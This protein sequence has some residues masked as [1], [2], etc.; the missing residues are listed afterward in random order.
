M[1]KVQARR[2]ARQLVLSFA[3]SAAG[4]PQIPASEA[5]PTAS[6]AP[7]DAGIQL[8][9]S[10][11]FTDAKAYFAEAVAKNPSDA[12][13]TY[14]LGRCGVAMNDVDAAIE[15]FE[16]AVAL[17]DASAVYHHWLGRA[18]GEKALNSGMFKKL[19]LAPKVRKEME[20]AVALDPNDLGARAD[21]L[22]YYMEAP[23]IVGGSA[24]KALEQAAEIRK[25]DALAGHYAYV[26]VYRRQK[27]N[28]LVEQEY[29]AATRENPA[30]TEP[31]IQLGFFYQGAERYDDALRV[32]E[33]IVKGDPNQTMALY[34]VGKTGA[35]SGRNLDR[36]AEC[37]LAYIQ[38]TPT[39]DEPPLTF[40]HY[41]LGQ[42][43]EKKGDVAA[44]KTEYAAALA[45]DPNNKDAKTALKKIS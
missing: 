12:E 45:L 8:F 33:G 10:K 21:L 13:S 27:K 38:H 22:D 41:R 30:K 43:Y 4:A 42:V 3:L 11:K 14:Y 1:T 17:Q 15:S 44:A 20:R 32:F 34:Q 29:L 26:N 18:Y 5:A 24:D 36:A 19:S 2:V 9:N 28:D 31:R 6:M 40:A 16:K 25:R 37:L 23:G 7:L 39:E 35:L